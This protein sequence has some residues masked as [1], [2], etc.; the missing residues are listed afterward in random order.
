MVRIFIILGLLLGGWQAALSQQ[1]A[2]FETTLYFEDAVGNRDSIVVG[3]DT[4]AT[5]DIDPEFGEVEILSPFDSIFEVRAGTFTWQ[6]REKLSKKIINR[7]TAAVGPFAPEDCYSGQPVFIYIWAK[8]QPIKVSWN[9]AVFAER[10]CYRATALLNHWL[11][12]L[13]GPLTPDEIPPEYACLAAEDSI[14]FDMS[15]EYLLSNPLFEA[16]IYLEKEVEGLGLQTIY[17]LRF[18]PASTPFDFSPCYW[19]TSSQ[20]ELLTGTVAPYPSP[21]V[22]TAYFN[23]PDGVEALRWQLF[24]INGV[25]MLEQRETGANKVELAGLPAGLYQLLVQGSD[26]KHYWGRVVKQ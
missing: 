4:L 2:Q 9:R 21:T 6:W 8:H 23:L 25:L 5:H 22:G 16:L 3:Y 18:F 1:T 15:E 14:Y 11:D 10:R 19:V 26:G 17:G 13:A 20:Q 12:E 7:A 24:G